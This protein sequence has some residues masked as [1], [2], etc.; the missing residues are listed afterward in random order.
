MT[1]STSEPSVLMRAGKKRLAIHFFACLV[2]ACSDLALAADI[3]LVSLSSEKAL[4][5]IDGKAPKAFAVGSSLTPDTKLA[6][7]DRTSATIDVAGKKQVLY[8]GQAHL[9]TNASSKSS[10]IT[11]S[12]NEMG[13][14]FTQ[15][16]INGAN[17]TKAVIDTGASFIAIPAA[18]AQ[19][20]GIDYKKGRPG[21]SS[22]ANGVVP[23]YLIQL[24][25]VKVGDIEVFQ[26][27]ASVHEG[28]L[29]I[30]L[31]GN[32][33]LRRVRMNRDGDQMVL[34]KK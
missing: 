4:F 29:P 1:M 24:D 23:T 2:C 3:K 8:L 32:S 14:F 12:A 26:V 18:E 33:F 22:T 27:Q 21:Y 17:P 15:V 30:T 6:A 9:A 11:L 19:R 25:S 7:L 31:L 10:S 16:Q 34:T 28:Q 13:H 20:M 5:I